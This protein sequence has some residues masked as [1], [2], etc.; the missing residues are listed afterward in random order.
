MAPRGASYDSHLSSDRLSRRDWSIACADALPASLVP[1]PRRP[2]FPST[3]WN[4]TGEAMASE[5]FLSHGKRPMLIEG[6]MLLGFHAMQ[7][8]SDLRDDGF[9]IETHVY[10]PKI[11]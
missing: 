6:G 8:L 11:K 10:N 1:N 9:L 3:S 7:T 5:R 2:A 4:C